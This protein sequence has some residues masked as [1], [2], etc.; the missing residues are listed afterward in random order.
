[1][2]FCFW[3][4]SLAAHLNS[5]LVFIS[6]F[7][8]LSSLGAGHGKWIGFWAKPCYEVGGLGAGNGGHGILR[9]FFGGKIFLD[10]ATA[11]G[12]HTPLASSPLLFSLYYAE[13]GLA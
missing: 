9:C 13:R 2:A 6:D 3:S 8:S 4:F 11:T 12:L 1:L 5:N 7:I 10:G